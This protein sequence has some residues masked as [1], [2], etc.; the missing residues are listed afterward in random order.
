MYV[1]Y[2][3]IFDQYQ[4]I[5]NF[6]IFAYYKD[7]QP[8]RY[9]IWEILQHWILDDGKREVV[10]RTHNMGSSGWCGDLEIRQKTVGNY[11]YNRINDVYAYRY[12]P[13]SIFKSCYS[14]YGINHKLQGITFLEAIRVLPKDSKAE[15]LYKAGQYNLLACCI[16]YTGKVSHRWPSIKICLRNKYIV[17]D[18]SIWMDYLDLLSYFGKD[19]RNAYYVCPKNL[20][21]AHDRLVAKKR[22]IQARE[23]AERKRKR[24]LENEKKF[25]EL[26]SKFFGIAFGDGNIQVRVLESVQEHMEE[27][28]ILKHCV[29]TNDYYIKADSLILSAMVKGKKT[30]TVEISIKQMKVVQCRGKQNKNTEYH[31]QIIELVNKNMNLIRERVKPKRKLK[32]SEKVTQLSH[33]V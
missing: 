24:A 16:D 19:L 22:K 14:L 8:P 28:D 5:R 13:D 7:N 32:T 33:A 26:K 12:H 15:T 11:Y 10:A 6:E 29:F 23:E 18:A 4:V 27:G 30:E 1:A 21:K 3:E 20:K 9:F 17:K 25:L 2:A 31:D